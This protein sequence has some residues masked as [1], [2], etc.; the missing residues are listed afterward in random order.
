MRPPLTS[1]VLT[2]LGAGASALVAT[3]ALLTSCGSSGSASE[4]S[5]ETTPSEGSS[6]SAPD[7]GA[8]GGGM[9]DA[10][11]LKRIRA[12]L[13]A[14]GLDDELPTGV[15]SGGPSGMPTDR[16]SDLPTGMP[17][18]MPTDMPTDMPSGGPGGL[19]SEEAQ[20]ALTA[21]GIEQPGPPAAAH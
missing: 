1:P 8:P 15:G 21:C 14:A 12:C 5:S 19:L 6:A 18:D 9:M 16:P 3:A 13:K 20:A 7:S 4:S 17:S 11:Q 10:A 2:R